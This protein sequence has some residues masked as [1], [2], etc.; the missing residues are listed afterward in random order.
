M[1]NTPNIQLACL[2][3]PPPAG[4]IQ[5]FDGY[6]PAL[7][8]NTYNINVS[9]NLTAPS[10]TSPSYQAQQTFIVQ[11]P[12]F[13]IDTTIIQTVYPPPGGSDVYGQQ[14][15]FL[16]MTDPSLPWERSL[17]PGQDQPSSTNPTS[18]MALLIFAEGEIYLQPN[19]NNPVSTT[20]VSKFLN[21]DS[22]M[23]AP[24]F[25][26]GWVSQDVMNSQCQTIT[27]TG[28]AFNAV[29]P[30]TTD[31]PYLVHCRAVNTLDE[32]EVLLS[33]LLSNRLPVTPNAQTTQR[34]FAH[35]V[36]LEGFAS[37]LGPNATPI[38]TK[39]NSTELMDVQLVS[40]FNWTFV[41]QPQSGFGFGELVQGLIQSEQS[42]STVPAQQ[43]ALS[44]PVPSNSNLPAT[45]QNRLQEGYVALEFISGS[46]DDSFAWYRGPFTATVP[47]PLPAIGDPATPV[48]QA[49][50]ADQLMIYLAEQ[51]LFDLSYAA[52][53]NLGRSLALA[54]AAF[55]QKVSQYRLSV[56]NAIAM[57]VQRMA[58]PLHAGETDF[59]SLLARDS[60][61]RRF[62]RMMRAGLGRQWTAALDGARQNK[63]SALESVPRQIRLR[64]RSIL[65]PSVLLGQS[66]VATAVSE[67]LNDTITSVAAW[68]ANLT[69]LYPIPFSYLIPDQRMLP[70]ESI[71]F[72]Y[73]D[74]NWIDALTAGALSI[75]IHSSSDVAVQVAMLPHLNRAVAQ[76]RRALLQTRPDALPTAGTNISGM[77]IRSQL[78]SGWPKLVISA[79]LGGAPVNI[80]RN[81]CPADNV[82]LCLFAGIPDTVTLA[83]P[84]QGLVFGLEG[85]QILP[86]CVTNGALTG[87]VIANVSAVTAPFRNPASGSLGGVL[88]VQN[89]ATALETAVGVTSF[90]TGAVVLW[91]Q[92]PLQTTVVGPNQ[93]SAIV[94]ASL[95]A[96]AGTAAITVQSG[97]ATSLPANFTIDA[98][99]QIDSINPTIMLA[100]SKDFVL[101]VSGVGF[102]TT[103][104][105]QWNGSPLTTTVISANEATAVV[106]AANVA[107][108][109]TAN[110]TVL[111][112]SVESNTVTLKIVSGDPVIDSLEPN[113]AAAGGAGF[114]L[115]VMGSGFNSSAVVQWNGDPLPTTFV[116]EQQLTAGVAANLIASAGAASV[117]VVIGETSSG[118]VNFTIAGAQ[119]TIGS[120]QPAVAMAG[121][122][123]FTLVVDGVNFNSD[124]QIQWNG[125]APF[126]T[127]FGDAEQLTATV[128]ASLLTS[129]GT[130]S[131]TVLSGGVTSNAVPFTIIGPQPAIGLLEPN[132]MIAGSPQFILTVTGGFGAGDFALQMVAA[133]EVQSFTTA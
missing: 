133:P 121:G 70:V 66:A 49:T 75:A 90:S 77:L 23:L 103:A 55:A 123:Q 61:R 53:W 88:E 83:E 17:V 13:F 62:A 60:S 85:G 108:T 102:A 122:G 45:V 10:G 114:A 35:L 79:T 80:I 87:A 2:P 76:Q 93:L 101:T 84:Y 113:I 4:S 43:G 7:F 46:G 6:F 92:T 128:P 107:A 118:P 34:Y 74:Q 65:Q 48:S 126:V 81:D 11:A 105:I 52:A 21:P 98:P 16:V 19:S 106:P 56:N 104:V 41:S 124:A 57:L 50:D 67:S 68:L 14:L 12:E 117:T 8:P 119:P 25:P 127:T 33:V 73:L 30:T 78:V 132:S 115:T 63:P 86:R 110:I 40:L 58:L 20:T 96:T 94:P 71:R 99:F 3:A 39:P 125:T 97:G 36:S 15:P 82:R 116:N 69:L 42:E 109:S 5:F 95:L 38:P 26:A 18:W 24:Q 28:A 54:D 44:L 112:N 29:L 72:F 37:F 100:G 27:I 22:N 51:G 64:R 89:V 120:L 131:I 47:Q 130:A 129:A 91:N 111:S 32:G 59:A 9:H 31:L 1:S